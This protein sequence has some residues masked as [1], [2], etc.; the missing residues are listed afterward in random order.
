MAKRTVEEEELGQEH[1]ALI[2][3]H[4]AAKLQMQRSKCLCLKSKYIVVIAI[5]FLLK[6]PVNDAHWTPTTLQTLVG[7][8][9]F[10]ICPANIYGTY[11]RLWTL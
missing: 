7:E 11:S 1:I 5:F 3:G 10:D 6:P 9:F 2:E 4:L 8:L